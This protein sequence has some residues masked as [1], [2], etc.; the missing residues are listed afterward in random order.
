MIRLA[1]A[2][3]DPGWAQRFE[4]HRA[5]IAAALDRRAIRIEHIGS[6]SVPG[7]AAK[8]VVDIVVEGVPHDDPAV[9]EALEN[10]G[11]ELAVDEPGH[12]MYKTPSRSAHVHFWSDASAAQEQIAFRD[13][14]RSHPED[15]ALYE[16]VKRELTEREWETRDHYADAKSAVVDTIMR[17]ARGESSHERIEYFAALLL[18]RLPPSAR[19]LEIGAGEGLL[20]KRLAQAGHRVV[21]LDTN[22]RSMFPILETSFE[23]FEAPAG[24]FECVA[25]QLVLHHA[26]G[27]SAMVA[28]IE[29][30]LTPDGLV[31]IDDYGWERSNDAAYR[32]K[33]CDLHTSETMLAAL[34]ERFD[35]TYYAEHDHV[36][37]GEGEGPLDFTFMGKRRI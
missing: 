34:R 30:L 13:W 10:G 16:H 7:L 24:S 1:L 28:K 22:L 9:R 6:T 5:R 36:R 12:R 31:A 14:L 25:A 21:A 8:P 23:T 37:G 20:A 29:Q 32:E 33:R 18:E 4:D 17:R 3:Y 15:R 27:L 11:Y 35:E 26:A 2:E 19:V